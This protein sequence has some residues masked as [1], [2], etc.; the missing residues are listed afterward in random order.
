MVSE[1]QK[2]G[3]QWWKCISNFIRG[4][5]KKT[6]G[7]VYAEL[8]CALNAMV[9]WR[10]WMYLKMSSFINSSL[11]QKICVPHLVHDWGELSLNYE[12]AMA[13]DGHEGSSAGWD[14]DVSSEAEVELWLRLRPNPHRTWDVMR[15]ATQANGICRCEWG[16]PHCTQ[17]TSKEKRSNL[18]ASHP[19]SCVDWALGTKSSWFEL[20]Q[21][22][23]CIDCFVFL[24]WQ[25]PSW[26]SPN[27]LDLLN[28]TSTSASGDTWD[29]AST[30]TPTLSVLCVQA[31][32]LNCS[33]GH[34]TMAWDLSQ[35]SSTVLWSAKPCASIAPF[36]HQ[37]IC[38][39][40]AFPDLMFKLSSQ[41]T[42]SWLEMCFPKLCLLLTSTP[43]PPPFKLLPHGLPSLSK[44]WRSTLV[45]RRK[46]GANAKGSL[47]SKLQ[48]E[49]QSFNLQ[50]FSSG[51]RSL[52]H[53]QESH[54]LNGH[55][56]QDQGICC[57]LCSANS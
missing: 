37:H 36:C 54:Q 13:P 24:Y 17:A 8:A 22:S 29:V 9:P 39:T 26:F 7:L 12:H 52:H 28:H 41:V 11:S 53:W 34:E 4:S 33:L 21:L 32:F 35:R 31:V 10:Q 30:Q 51:T 1:V 23:A 14:V 3:N 15:N 27:G 38:C 43:H 5:K 42:R 46:Q 47:S 50:T 18:H 2:F 16:C 57:L 45:S 25:V 48:L 20:N 19:S 49:R 44:G 55:V 40:N 56:G 6:K